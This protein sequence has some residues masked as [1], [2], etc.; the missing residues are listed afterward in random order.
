M[1]DILD[2][3]GIDQEN[4]GAWV[5]D[6]PLACHGGE[7]LESLNPASGEVIARVRTAT[8]DEYEQV[9]AGAREAFYSWRTTPAPRRGEAIRLI[10]DALRRHKDDLGSLV[11]MEMGKIKA[12]GDG[13]V[14]EMIDIA[15][16]AV[17]QSRM[18]YGNTMH[19]ERPGHRMYEQWHPLG[20]VGIISAFNFPVA[21]WSWNA[22]IAAVCG[23]TCVWKPSPKA[24]LTAIAPLTHHSSRLR[25]IS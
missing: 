23:D 7:L 12:E 18:L 8:R 5:G 6:R 10:G 22:F 4:P 20:L 17:G 3:L 16:F 24:P 15:D 19:S 21:V 25:G 1:K 11:T 14:Q 2:R 9:I 13:E